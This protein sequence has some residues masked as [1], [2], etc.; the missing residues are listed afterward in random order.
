MELDGE[1]IPPA[2]AELD[3]APDMAVGPRSFLTGSDF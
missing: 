2:D 1:I 3:T